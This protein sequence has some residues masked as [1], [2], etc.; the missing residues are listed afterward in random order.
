VSRSRFI[1]LGIYS[2]YLRNNTLTVDDCIQKDTLYPK[3]TRQGPSGVI[4]GH[5]GSFREGSRGN[6]VPIVKVLKNGRHCEPLKCTRLQDFAYTIYKFIFGGDT[7]DLRS[8]PG[9]CTQT[10]ISSFAR[11]RS[12]CFCCTKLNL[13]VGAMKG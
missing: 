8:A 7:P 12:H 10:P 5:Q 1:F 2:E 13:I 6:G 11:Q 3:Y 9:A 4:R